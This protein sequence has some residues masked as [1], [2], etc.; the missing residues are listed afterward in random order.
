MKRKTKRKVAMILAGL[1]AGGAIASVLSATAQ[2]QT[3]YVNSEDGLRV[4]SAPDTESEIL[5]V[6]EF[7]A[8]VA[9]E[10]KQGEWLRVEGGNYILEEHTQETDPLE[11]MELLGT[12]RITAYAETGFCCANGNYPTTGYT[13]ACN[14]LAFGTKVYIKGVGFRVVEDRGPAWL[15]PQ[16][17]DLYLGE[18]QDCIQWGDQYREVYLCTGY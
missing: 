18:T 3:V 15:G 5:Q 11:E 2:A 8:E 17:C 10:G 4:R 14:S 16:W 6:L 13:I 1:T 12:W 9:V 7:G